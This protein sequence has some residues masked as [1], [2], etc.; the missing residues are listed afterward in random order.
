MDGLNRTVE[1][2]ANFEPLALAVLFLGLTALGAI[3]LAAKAIS[4][5]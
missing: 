4:K 5:R 2:L 3:W 1:A